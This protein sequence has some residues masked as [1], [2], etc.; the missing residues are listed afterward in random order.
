MPKYALVPPP[1]LG[2][3]PLHAQGEGEN[4]ILAST[5]PA[6]ARTSPVMRMKEPT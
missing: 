5:Y 3:G 1:F 2:F 4:T 6:H